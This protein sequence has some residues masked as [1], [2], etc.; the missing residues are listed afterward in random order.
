MDKDWMLT[1]D[2]LALLFKVVCSCLDWLPELCV[3]AGTTLYHSPLLGSLAQYP[4]FLA[5]KAFRVLA[6]RVAT[7]LENASSP[8]ACRLVPGQHSH[9]RLA[10]CY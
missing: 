10:C 5:L 9:G 2:V 6:F 7:R 8:T 4:F 1:R 3:G